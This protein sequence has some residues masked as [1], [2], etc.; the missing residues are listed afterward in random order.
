[1]LDENENI[2][3]GKQAKA[4]KG[5][6]YN[7]IDSV[8]SKVGNLKSPTYYRGQ[9]QIDAT[10][11]L[12]NLEA[13]KATELS[14]FSIGNHQYLMIDVPEKLILGKKITKIQRPYAQK[15]I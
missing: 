7:M 4:L 2:Q 11:I 15:L 13:T 9:E 3:T 6:P 10:W 1:M 8:R 14:F 5:E 12:K